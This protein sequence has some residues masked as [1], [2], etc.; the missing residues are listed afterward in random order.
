VVQEHDPPFD[1]IWFAHLRLVRTILLVPPRS[2]Q[3]LELLLSGEHRGGFWHWGRLWG[4]AGVEPV[5]VLAIVAVAGVIRDERA[6]GEALD[7]G[8]GR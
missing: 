4:V 5:Q 8:A 1:V 7:A 6:I 3:R 2:A